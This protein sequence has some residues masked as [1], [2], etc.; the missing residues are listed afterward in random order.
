MEEENESIYKG[1]GWSK[2]QIFVL[3]QLDDH[4]KIL[5]KLVDKLSHI[6]LQLE[7][8]QKELDAIKDDFDDINKRLDLLVEEDKKVGKKILDFET[9]KNVNVRVKAIWIGVGGAIVGGVTLLL[10]WWGHLAKLLNP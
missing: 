7:M 8:R 1:N 10:Q 3:K 4:N 6:T 9:D 2:Y 5:E